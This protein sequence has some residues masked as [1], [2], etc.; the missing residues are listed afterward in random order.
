MKIKI[1]LT[2]IVTLILSFLIL[3]IQD[4]IFLS[5]G[6]DSLDRAIVPEQVTQ[7]IAVAL[8]F[9]SVVFSQLFTKS[10][11][12]YIFVLKSL[13]LGFSIIVVI[14]SGHTYTISGKQHAFLDQ[15]FHIPLQKLA[16][17]PDEGVENLSYKVT[18]RFVYLYD[19]DEVQQSILLGPLV[20]GL[21]EKDIEK[22]LSG[23][24][25]KNSQ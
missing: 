23:F 20:W 24:N 4:P 18:D 1:S 13:V 25:V 9:V 19:A 17:N 15:W 10:N 8:F 14:A 2:I 21:D 22:A 6:S 16:F 5:S 7:W 3:T 12:K 11:K